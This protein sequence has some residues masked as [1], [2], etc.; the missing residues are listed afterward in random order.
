MKCGLT[1]HD[2]DVDA[3]ATKPLRADT[4]RLSS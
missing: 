4:A 2:D 3:A 1:V